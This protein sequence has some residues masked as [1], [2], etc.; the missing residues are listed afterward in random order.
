MKN[1]IDLR[2][3]FRGFNCNGLTICYQYYDDIKALENLFKIHDSYPEVIKKSVKF[4]IID[5]CSLEFPIHEFKL[6]LDKRNIQSYQITDI[7]AW[8]QGG[9]RNLNAHLSN[10]GWS[11][12][13]DIDHFF[14]ADALM[15]LLNELESLPRSCLYHFGR[16][17]SNDEVIN[18]HVNTYLL[19]TNDFILQG[20]IDE[21]FVGQYGYEDKFFVE[22]AKLRGLKV[23]ELNNIYVHVLNIKSGNQIKGENRS[24]DRNK[25]LYRI[26]FER[27]SFRSFLALRFS[28]KNI[29]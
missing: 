13:S 15:L 9:A 14:T 20:G 18:K 23:V 17:S 21:D 2:D 16:K 25:N 19:R 4:Q 22:E 5:D 29:S 10:T 12:F 28:Y 8:N 24:I 3:G 11:L 7:I 27:A 26:K 6:E 1:F